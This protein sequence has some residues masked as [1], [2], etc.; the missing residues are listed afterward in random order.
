MAN[1]AIDILPRAIG[2]WW[3]TD[4]AR[5]ERTDVDVVVKGLDGELLVGECKWETAPVGS[6]VIGVL[7]G[8]AGL[9]DA[10]AT[11]VRLALFSKSGFTDECEAEAHR[12]GNVQL[13][14][15]EEM[16]W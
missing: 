4:P 11:D 3:G 15:V 10:N 9:V 7:A 16:F 8:R 14:N 13:V 12:R 1:G 2:S 6:D 5:R